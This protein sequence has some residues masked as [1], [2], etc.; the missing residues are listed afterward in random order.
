[1]N[2]SVVRAYL[3]TTCSAMG[4]DIGEVWWV[5]PPK[6]GATTSSSAATS[7]SDTSSSDATD[8]NMKFVQL[9][10]SKSYDDQRKNLIVPE[11][12]ED[13]FPEDLPPSPPSADAAASAA[14]TTTTTTTTVV[15]NTRSSRGTAPATTTSS[16]ISVNSST[17]PTKPIIRSTSGTNLADV[18]KHVLS[19][20]LVDAIAKSTQV[21]WANC[22]DSNGLLGRS[23]MKLQTA[24]GLPVAVDS[25]GNMCVVLMFSPRNLESSK[26][27]MEY[28]QAIFK[29]ASGNMGALLPVLPPSESEDADGGMDSDEYDSDDTD[30]SFRPAHL[31]A[32][33]TTHFLSLRKPLK[34]SMSM[35]ALSSLA[36]E[37]SSSDQVG[38]SSS[39]DGRS[40]GGI[41]V[42]HVHA[43]STAPRDSF[44][45]PMLPSSSEMTEGDIVRHSSSASVK[46]LSERTAETVDDTDS[47]SQ[48]PD[49]E[50]DEFA[51]NVWEAV[52]NP[53]TATTSTAI[54]NQAALEVSNVDV[55]SLAGKE[56]EPSLLEL[57]NTLL[58]A[59]RPSSGFILE[60]TTRHRVEEFVRGFLGLSSFDAADVFFSHPTHRSLTQIF[61]LGSETAPVEFECFRTL[62]SPVTLSPWEG[63]AGT[64]YSTANPLW[65]SD[66]SLV[67]DKTR[68]Q[69][70]DKID[71]NTILAVPIIGGSD[72]LPKFVVCFYSRDVVECVP[73]ALRFVQQAVKLIWSEVKF[74]GEVGEFAP[75]DAGERVWQD[76]RL[77]DL[78]E[79]AANIEQQ[80]QFTKKRNYE[81]SAAMPEMETLKVGSPTKR[82]A[83]SAMH[84]SSTTF[85]ANEFVRAQQARGDIN[86][87]LNPREPVPTSSG[88]KPVSG[89]GAA[90]A[91]APPQTLPV[92]PG[93]RD[94]AGSGGLSSPPHQVNFSMSFNSNDEDDEFLL[95]GD[96]TRPMK[97]RNSGTGL[98]NSY[99]AGSYGAG[100]YGGHGSLGS[101]AY[102]HSSWDANYTSA[103]APVSPGRNIMSG[104]A[105]NMGAGVI[106]AYE[107]EG[108]FEMA[109]GDDY[110][111]DAYG[112][113]YY[114]DEPPLT[115]APLMP[116]R[117]HSFMPPTHLQ[118]HAQQKPA[119]R[120][121]KGG[122]S[123][124]CRILGCED[125]SIA[126]RPYCFKHSGSR[127][128]E[129]T[130]PGGCGKCAQGSTR[131]CIAHGGGRR[132]TFQGCD[133]GA[134]DKYFCAAHGGGKRC[135]VGNCT[136]S[137]VGG[138]S[139]CTSH[140]G[141]KR[142]QVVGC[143]KSAQSSTNFCVKHGGGKKCIHV[144]D[145][146][147]RCDRVARGRTDFCASHGGGVRCKLDGCNRVAIGK[148]QLC[149]SHGSGKSAGGVMMC[150]DVD[151][152]F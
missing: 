16:A 73:Y 104:S 63:A 151:E 87:I 121:K 152:G 13:E 79:I 132:C 17:A 65:S 33:T 139:Q 22:Q 119:A 50:V 76:V 89:I 55:G 67:Y 117:A 68:A 47:G 72:M 92:P 6:P 135:S 35:P 147:K 23:D 141:G 9:Y 26:D 128:C 99:G 12:D 20:Q 71:V 19:P 97:R 98:A 129:Y 29:F 40:S 3:Q 61:T 8:G 10:T 74:E 150:E 5:M 145:N 136:K 108:D 88:A 30:D 113:N 82:K 42:T 144:S 83:E 102:Q 39:Y 62:T 120:G 105:P 143:E 70:F 57:P 95:E 115:T 126:R 84:Y 36:A 107:N 28:L 11:E 86:R 59:A 124:L 56:I 78:G 100:N 44:G 58:T 118:P 101:F 32:S 31:P 114:S 4:F 96:R 110:D 109:Y 138:S 21:I 1:M 131:F 125:N 34:R 134:R 127:Q 51:Y 15:H 38:L 140:G 14:T 37:S 106:D 52:L 25:D 75:T 116:P 77:N 94:R 81:A 80:Q 93:Q 43:L 45:I 130:G 24:V 133:K 18:A 149:R 60:E 49:S 123:K 27:S 137:A 85:R 111:N 103:Y 41:Q 48:S 53:S 91:N 46:S 122:N 146:N 2:P 66:R 112:N 7:S 64:A 69:L 90:L 54:L 142:C 148:L